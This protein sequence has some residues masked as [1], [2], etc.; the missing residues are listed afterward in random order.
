MKITENYFVS[1]VREHLDGSYQIHE[2]KDVL[3]AL[4]E[5]IEDILLGGNSIEWHDFG[6]FSSANVQARMH[7]NPQD[8][9]QKFNVPAY[10]KPKFTFSKG[11]KKRMK[12]KTLNEE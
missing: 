9:T 7:N 12:E 10:R 2:I 4:K 6:V 8:N 1:Y 11:A 3:D 5:C